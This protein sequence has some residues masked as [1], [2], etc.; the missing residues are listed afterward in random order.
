[1]QIILPSLGVF[2]KRS[3]N[4]RPATFD[5]LRAVHTMNE[6]CEPLVKIQFVQRLCSDLDLSK[7]SKYDLDYLYAVAALSISF[8]A[9]SYTVTCPD[10]GELLSKEFLFSE[11]EIKTLPKKVKFPQVRKIGGVDYAFHLLSGQNEMDA[12]EYAMSEDDFDVAYQDAIACF[13]FGKGLE[14]VDEVRGYPA[15]IFLAAFIFQQC[16]FHGLDNAEE[17]ECN[18]C[19]KSILTRVALPSSL[20]QVDLSTIT[21]QYT[22]V[23]DQMSFDSFL[24]FTIPEFE[25]LLGTLNAQ[26]E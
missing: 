12:I 21:A 13:T 10:C 4:M 2:G 16:C 19:H 11:K 17:V 1:M 23:S 22:K 18:N 25:T 8:N 15:S 26:V 20:I 7:I 6:D 3:V 5:D 9:V 24:S 14:S